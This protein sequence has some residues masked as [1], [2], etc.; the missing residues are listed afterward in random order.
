[1]N[2]Q[3]TPRRLALAASV[4]SALWLA[5]CGSTG[6]VPGQLSGASAD[7]G[8]GPVPSASSASSARAYRRDAAR[9]VYD[10]NRSRIYKGQLPPVLYAVGTLEVNIDAGGKVRSMHWLRAPKHAPE[11]IA[12]IERT[13]LKAS[14][15]PPATRLGSVTWTDTWLWDESGR[16]QLDTLTEGQQQGD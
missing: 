5:G 7:V 16:F 14:P 8:A 12:E 11:V 3:L 15:F 10:A 1:M 4:V 9:H 6:S 2:R 13:V